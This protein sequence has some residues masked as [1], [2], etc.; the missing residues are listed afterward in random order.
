MGRNFP[1]TQNYWTADFLYDLPDEAIE[2]HAPVAMR[3]I[4]PESAILLIPGGGAPSRVGEEETA[5]G[6]RTAPWNVHYICG[7]QN[8]ADNA[9]NIELVKTTAAILKPWA[10]GQ[11]YLNYIGN[12]GQKRIDTAFGEHK[13]RRLRELKRKWDPHNVFRHNHNIRPA[14]DPD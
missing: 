14:A 13:M 3:P 2:A 8:P 10:T 12:E 6:M 9:R 4:S 1:G 7:W 11:V 5:F